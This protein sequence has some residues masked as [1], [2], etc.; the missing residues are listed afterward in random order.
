MDGENDTVYFFTKHFSM[1]SVQASL[2][3]QLGP[4]Q[5]SNM[6]I[7]PGH[8]DECIP[9]QTAYLYDSNGNLVEKAVRSRNAWPLRTKYEYDQ[10]GNIVAM[11]SPSGVETFYEYSAAY[12]HALLTKV[13]L[14][15][16]TDADHK[17]Q[18]NVVLQ[19]LGYDP[20][21]YRKRWEKDARG[22]VTEYQHDA[23]GREIMTV[24]PDDNDDPAYRPTVLSGEIDRIGF[25]S[26]NPVRRVIYKDGEKT[27]T[28]IVPLENRTD[29]IYDS[30]EH[31]V[32]MVKFKK[33]GAG[34]YTAYSRVK[35]NYDND[36]NIKE[37]IS[38]EGNAHPEMA[39]KYTTKYLYDEQNRLIRI[40][41]PKTNQDE[42]FN[43]SKVYFYN[44]LTNEVTVLDENNNETI[45]RKDP[46]GRVIEEIAG[47][48]TANQI[49]VQYTYDSLGNKTSETIDG[50]ITIRFEYNDLNQLV[51]KI[52]PRDEVLNDP[53]GQPVEKSPVYQYEYDLEGNLVKEISPLGTVITHVYDELNREIE[54]RTEF[55]RLDGSTVTSRTKT[56]YDLTGNKIKVVDPNGKTTEMTYTAQGLLATHK[57]P[58]GGI[59]GS[60]SSGRPKRPRR[61]PGH[62]LCL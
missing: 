26:D 31:L 20:I 41:Y 22:F 39:E 62:Y 14:G 58:M 55:T 33:S 51:R 42:Q 1:F 40:E 54:T 44:D 19:E 25:R 18:T 52:L 38:P 28:V 61:Q 23:I 12:Q 6:G 50:E 34:T 5:I 36:G 45:I 49:S 53:D 43:P 21:T 8:G 56:Y 35:V 17:V 10:Y 47:F 30:F 27:T 2:A 15:K 59:A 57:D 60:D 13:I 29:Y 4:E 48:R 46:V 7:S 32:E 3:L 11:T 37:I 9:Q 16:L 24:L